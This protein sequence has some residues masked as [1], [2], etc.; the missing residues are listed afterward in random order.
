MS[1]IMS[2]LED[3]DTNILTT[4]FCLRLYTFGPLKNIVI[5]VLVRVRSSDDMFL[6]LYHD[7]D[8]YNVYLIKRPY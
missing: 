6:I 5:H 1:V 8:N 3:N 2:V 7:D 4:F